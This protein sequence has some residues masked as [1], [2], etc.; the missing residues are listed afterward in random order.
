MKYL[1]FLFI[2]TF[3]SYAFL[4]GGKL[5]PCPNT[6]NC[7]NSQDEKENYIVDPIQTKLSI[8]EIVKKLKKTEGI[9]HVKTKN[10]LIHFT[11]TSNVFKFKDDIHIL[12]TPDKR[13]HIRSA[14]RSG[15][16]DF[17]A[18]KNRVEQIRKLLKK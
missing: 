12:W 6:P 18:N 5:P 4:V 14:S 16:F 15:Y 1:I 8:E 7:V 17:K 2:V 13:V 10:N 11:H 3:S 9:E